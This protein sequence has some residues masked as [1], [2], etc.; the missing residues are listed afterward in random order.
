VLLLENSVAGKHD[1]AGLL[2]HKTVSGELH[3]QKTGTG[4]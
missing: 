1:L 3:K 2:G 4:K